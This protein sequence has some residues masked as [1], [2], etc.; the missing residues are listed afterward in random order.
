MS[1][2]LAKGAV[3][4]WLREE[5]E[6]K[7]KGLPRRGTRRHEEWGVVVGVKGLWDV[8]ARLRGEVEVM[9]GG[10]TGPWGDLGGLR[11]NRLQIRSVCRR[12]A[13]L[14][15]S[16]AWAGHAHLGHLGKSRS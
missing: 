7:V 9:N 6:G 3:R 8:L 11:G 4:G 15:R 12:G 10:V 14:R 13:S 1:S 2:E 5:Q 16:I